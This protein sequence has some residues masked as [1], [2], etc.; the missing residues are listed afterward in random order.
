[1]TSTTLT[2]SQ[3]CE[4]L[5]APSSVREYQLEYLD[6]WRKL[7]KA[8]IGESVSF[9]FEGSVYKR[10]LHK[11]NMAKHVCADWAGLTWT[12]N[13]R[14]SAPEAEQ[15][16][17]DEV[18]DPLWHS[19]FSQRLEWM[20]ADGTAAIEVLVDGMEVTEQGQV[21]RSEDV[22]IRTTFVESGSLYPLA[23]DASGRWTHF[24]IVD[25][26]RQSSG[27]VDVRMY[28]K[29]GD[30]WAV[31]NRALDIESK[32]YREPPEGVVP[33]VELAGAPCPV[34]ILKPAL[35][36]NVDR[37][38]PY[39]LSVL[40]NAE[41]QLA[42][43]DDAFDLFAE[44][45]RLSQKMVF[46]SDQLLRRDS[47]GKLRVPQRDRQNLFAPVE[48]MGDSDLIKEYN[49][50][51][52]ADSSLTAIK[53]ALASLSAAVGM[54]EGRYRWGESGV[55]TATEIIAQ[56]SEL[57]RNRRKHWLAVS[58][59]VRE[60]ARSVLWF[61]RE[62]QGRPVDP[63]VDIQVLSD[64]S[65]IEDDGTRIERGLRL[66]TTGAISQRRFLTEYLGLSEQ[67]AEAEAAAAPQLFA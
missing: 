18:F 10:R 27:Y 54:G 15:K 36:N 64:D 20:Y 61:A 21:L 55:T 38:N 19:W 41:E 67:E 42:T 57:F 4:K 26:S 9:T 51:M 14:L 43:V 56:N 5:G 32:R 8:D 58:S 24:A 39:G 37:D 28:L 1:M 16:V 50:E 22:T 23:W 47:T 12:E 30:V 62:V 35:A 31:A 13:V 60:A 7:Y 29:A 65:V 48:A 53:L 3:L 40:A 66:F 11:T 2:V 17:L 34:S 33:Y 63:D 25:W 46:I 6:R 59:A 45:M 44:D 49:P 52:R